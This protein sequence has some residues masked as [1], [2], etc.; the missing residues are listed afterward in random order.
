LTIAMPSV[1]HNSTRFASACSSHSGNFW[2][3]CVWHPHANG[4][5][6]WLWIALSLVAGYAV[7]LAVRAS[8]SLWRM[9]RTLTCML[10]LSARPKHLTGFNVLEA[11]EPL[12]LAFGLGRGQILLSTSLLKKLDPTQLH[13]VLAHEQAHLA[14]RDLLYRLI[15]AILS[16][17]Q[18]PGPRRRLLREFE[19]AL[20][21]RCDQVAAASVGSPLLVAETIIAVERIFQHQKKR[22]VAFS[23]GFFLDFVPERVHELLTPGLVRIRG[24]TCILAA[25]TISFCALS[26]GWLHHLTEALLSMWAY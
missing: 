11:E 7:W 15:A 3:Y 22:H 4:Q 25:G 8:L 1:L 14:N 19:L 26:A 23:M 18:L 13:I 5:S 24:L 6:T 12:A 20:E 10:R 21:Q 9:R 16:C 17:V 2:H